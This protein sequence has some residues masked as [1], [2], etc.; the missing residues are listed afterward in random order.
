MHIIYSWHSCDFLNQ[1]QPLKSTLHAN[2]SASSSEA[3]DLWPTIIM[4]QAALTVELSRFILPA[5]CSKRLMPGMRS[6]PS[7][8]ACFMLAGF[9]MPPFLCHLQVVVFL[10]LARLALRQELALAAFQS[11]E[12][13]MQHDLVDSAFSAAAHQSARAMHCLASCEPGLSHDCS[14]LLLTLQQGSHLCSSG[15]VEARRQTA[16][17]T[18]GEATDVPDRLRQPP[19]ILLPITSRPYATTS[20]CEG[21]S[22]SSHAALSMQHDSNSIIA[23]P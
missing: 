2:K 7:T 11:S 8:R 19:C 10:T 15:T 14:K 18:T 3:W 9:K 12:Q 6:A 5:P 22:S 16:P 23:A 20:G 4:Q 1:V 17:A 21:Q 13:M